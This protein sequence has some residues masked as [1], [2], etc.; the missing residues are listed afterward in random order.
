M[1]NTA[2][3]YTVYCICVSAYVLQMG[4]FF[5]IGGSYRSTFSPHPDTR[6]GPNSQTC[7]SLYHLPNS[8]LSFHICLLPHYLC[9]NAFVSCVSC[10]VSYHRD[11]WNIVFRVYWS[12]IVSVSWYFWFAVPRLSDFCLFDSHSNLSVTSH[13]N[14]LYMLNDV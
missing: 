11:W 12:L 7:P 13:C 1:H 9:I 4:M 5:F 6:T 2:L 8:F 3:V 14:I 10:R